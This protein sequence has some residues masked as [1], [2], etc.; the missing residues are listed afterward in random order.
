MICLICLI[1]LKW[2]SG[3]CNELIH[4]NRFTM[5]C[6][7]NICAKNTPHSMHKDLRRINVHRHRA[8]E[9]LPITSEDLSKY[10]QC[11]ARKTGPKKSYQE[12]QVISVPRIQDFRSQSDVEHRMGFVRYAQMFNDDEGQ[13]RQ[14]AMEMQ[15]LFHAGAQ[16]PYFDQVLELLNDAQAL[17]RT[18]GCELLRQ[19]VFWLTYVTLTSTCILG[20]LIQNGLTGH[21]E[22]RRHSISTDLSSDSTQSSA[23]IFCNRCKS[24]IL[25]FQMCMGNN[26]AR[27][28]K[29]KNHIAISP[30][31]TQ[32]RNSPNL[33]VKVRATRTHI[34]IRI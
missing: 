20:E 22:L 9:A 3:N 1:C 33:Y 5:Q 11:L 17:C 29:C 10:E 25:C 30:I 19:Q 16:N 4:F 14:S 31:R 12:Y 32:S 27:P 26:Y 13:Q 21:A 6:R 7:C 23:Y 15:S 28:Y 24:G 18:N 34:T 2:C 8:H